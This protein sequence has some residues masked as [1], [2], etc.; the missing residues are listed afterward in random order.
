MSSKPHTHSARAL[1]RLIPALVAALALSLTAAGSAGAVAFEWEGATI[2]AVDPGSIATDAAGRVYVPIRNQAKVNIYDNARGGNRLLASIGTAAQLQDPTAVV[3]DLRGYIYVADAAKNAIVAFTPYYWGANYLATTGTTGPALGQ[4][5]GLRQIAA[6][7]EPRIYAAEADNG[8]VQSLDPARGALTSL[9]A[10]GVTDPGPWGPL[11]GIAIDENERIVV[12]SASP[13]DAPRLYNGNGSFV[14]SIESAGPA[15]GQVSG[16]LGLAFDPVDRLMV[17]DTGNDRVD[18]F[19][20]VA[21]GL[22]FLAQFGSAGSG[23]GQFDDP[24]SVATAPGA[25]V[26]VADTGNSR[27]V[28][29]RYDDTDR[30]SALDARDNCLGLANASQGDVDADRIGDDC[31]PD[32]DGDLYPNALDKCPLLKPWTDR[33]KDGCQDP[34]SKLSQLRKSSRY[35]ALRGSASGGSLGLARVEVAIARPGAKLRY[36]R[37]RGTKRWS[38]R[39]T[40]RKLASGRYRVYTRAVQKRGGLVEAPKGARATFR[41]DR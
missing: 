35:V 36:V 23:D 7:L 31:D 24:G 10:F 40:M 6:D 29:L 5:S 8:R 25:L 17:A 37:A 22:G 13:T 28:R 38:L 21:G 1:R 20:S 33:N 3:I 30:D 11:A 41:I 39:V 9:F 14:G 19:N 34:F 4:F 12:S 18:L 2:T 32:I 15:P 16:P 27:I 26:Y